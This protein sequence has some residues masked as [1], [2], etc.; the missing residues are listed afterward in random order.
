MYPVHC[1]SNE[2]K[3][4]QSSFIDEIDAKFNAGLNMVMFGVVPPELH[5]LLRA[6]LSELP[7]GERKR[8]VDA[9]HD[10]QAVLRDHC[11]K[12]AFS[13]GRAEYLAPPNADELI[14]YK[15][16]RIKLRGPSE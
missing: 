12:A 5:P 9:V 1:G 6:G 13:S 11:V 15:Q 4:R 7:H 8:L 10:A 14:D 3:R 2:Y 16:H